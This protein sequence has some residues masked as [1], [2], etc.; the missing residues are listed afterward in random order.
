MVERIWDSPGF[1]APMGTASPSRHSAE[2]GTHWLELYRAALLELDLDKLGERV[3]TAEAAIRARASLNG[4]IL[5][6]ERIAIQDATS[7]LNVLK[8]GITRG[9]PVKSL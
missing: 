1:Y 9:N 6:D 2:D 7:A 5:S 8:A 4:N 3:K